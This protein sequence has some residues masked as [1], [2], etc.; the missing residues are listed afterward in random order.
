[1][2]LKLASP[3]LWDAFFE[4]SQYFMRGVVDFYK[5]VIFVGNKVKTSMLRN[6]IYERECRFSIQTT[7]RFMHVTCTR[8]SAIWWKV[9]PTAVG[10][11]VWRG[12]WI[13]NVVWKKNIRFVIKKTC[14]KKVNTVPEPLENKTERELQRAVH[15]TKTGSRHGLRIAEMLIL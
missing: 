15:R 9:R 6:T 3:Q 5:T 10:M 2:A 1:M 13:K 11:Q 14:G 8:L 7:E 12:H 4:K